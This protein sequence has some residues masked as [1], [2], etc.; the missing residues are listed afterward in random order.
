MNQGRLK[1]FQSTLRHRLN[2]PAGIENR[3]NPL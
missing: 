3:F 1:T 2:P